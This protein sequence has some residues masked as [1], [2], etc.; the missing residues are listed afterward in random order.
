MRLDEIL[1]V[2]GP[3]AK[4]KRLV[5]MLTPEVM[6]DNHAAMVNILASKLSTTEIDEL[7]AELDGGLLSDDEIDFY[8]K[9]MQKALASYGQTTVLKSGN[10]WMVV[11]TLFPVAV[12]SA[13]NADAVYRKAQG[14]VNAHYK[15]GAWFVSS[16]DGSFS[17]SGNLSDKKVKTAKDALA[18]MIG[19]IQ[20]AQKKYPVALVGTKVLK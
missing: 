3:V 5:P 15:R 20:K 16:F 12:P 6:A 11:Q 2:K 10:G 17:G 8:V 19:A 14:H 13:L 18:L 1:Q 9:M 4:M 7:E